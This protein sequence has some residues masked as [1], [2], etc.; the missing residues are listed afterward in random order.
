MDANK[1]VKKLGIRIGELELENTMLKV[2]LEEAKDNGD[3][4]QKSGSAK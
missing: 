1:L 4:S 2:Q 3:R